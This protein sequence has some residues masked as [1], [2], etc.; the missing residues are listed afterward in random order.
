[1]PD[2]VRI[3]MLQEIEKRDLIDRMFFSMDITRKS[4]MEHKGGIGYCYLFDTFIKNL[5][6]AGFKANSIE[7]ILKENP[8][9]FYGQTED[10]H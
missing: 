8:K 7:K 10:K 3:S 9:K 6:G 4:N 5:L 1:M 2:D